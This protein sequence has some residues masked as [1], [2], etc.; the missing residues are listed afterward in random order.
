MSDVKSSGCPISA[1]SQGSPAAQNLESSGADAL[2]WV[3]VGVVLSVTLAIAPGT[4]LYF[5]VTPKVVALLL[6]V[7]A[8]LLLGKSR[9]VLFPVGSGTAATLL[10][11]YVLAQTISLFLSTV[12][13]ARAGLSLAGTNWRRL[14]LFSEVS[15]VLFLLLTAKALAGNRNRIRILL[16]AVAVGAIATSG[17]AFLQYARQDPLLQAYL[18]V[19][20]YALPLLR[21]VSTF[22][23]PVYFANYL[24][25]AIFL[26]VGSAYAETRRVWR[27]VAIAG[28]AFGAFALL[29]SGTRAAWLG[30]LI[31]VALWIVYGRGRI[32]LRRSALIVAPAMAL[33]AAFYLS[34]AGELFRNRIDQAMGD[35]GGTRLWVWHDASPMVLDRPIA[36]YGLET[37]AAVFPTYQSQDFARAYPDTLNESPHNFL[38]DVAISQGLPGTIAVLL[39]IATCV[40]SSRQARAKDPMLAAILLAGFAGQLAAHMFASLTLPTALYLYLT[41]AILLALGLPAEAAPH[42][43]RRLGGRF[44]RRVKAVA[45]AI[46]CIYAVQLGLADHMMANVRDA[47]E[48]GDLQAALNNY[49]IARQWQPIGYSSD[50]WYAGSLLLVADKTNQLPVISDQARDAALRAVNNAED[51]QNAAYQLATTY[52]V[53]GELDLAHASLLKAIE[54]A[55]HWYRP[56]WA[57][58]ELL[59]SQGNAQEA[60]QEANIAHFL[61]NGRESGIDRTLEK[62]QAALV[63]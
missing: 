23:H 35:W 5:D 12:F 33:L 11:A 59:L 58:A 28:A 45:A 15:L 7:S 3:L 40:L 13:S 48:R 41:V 22:G 42:A 62:I 10:N 52:Q 4:L 63:P 51:P 2:T 56:H 55:P 43:S 21:P 29:L 16:R 37:F 30:L 47:L 38:L 36:G 46:F 24:V 32:G 8:G 14:G 19:N 27:I 54:I 50:A 61:N 25:C 57:L 9:G 39:L 1:S 31:G 6:G 53:R 49:R 20:S 60:L 17:Y 18:N 44:R 26:C 34:P